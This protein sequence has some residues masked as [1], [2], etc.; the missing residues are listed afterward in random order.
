M[1][2]G[3]HPWMLVGPWYRWPSPGVPSS[4]RTTAPILQKYETADYINQFLADPQHSLVFNENEDRVFEITPR[5]PPLPF[6]NGKATS[7]AVSLPGSPSGSSDNLMQSTGIRKLFLDTQKRFYLVVC[8][9]HC[10]VAG[11][12]QVDRGDVCEIGRASCRER[13]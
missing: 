3:T 9:L 5:V 6:L 4:G 13:V 2:S 8:E 1:V 12:P 10:D 11:F 7:I